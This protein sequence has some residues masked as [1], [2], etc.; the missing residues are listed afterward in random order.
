MLGIDPRIIEKEIATY[1]DAKLVRQ[2][3]HLVNFCKATAIKVELEKIL[4]D[5]FIYPI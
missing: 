3:L 5:G 4:K 1:P 2:K